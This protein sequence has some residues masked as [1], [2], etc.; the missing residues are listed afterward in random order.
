MTDLDA[1]TRS[2][3]PTLLGALEEDGP[4]DLNLDEEAHPAFDAEGEVDR[5]ALQRAMRSQ[6]AEVLRPLLD[7]PIAR[8]LL[9]AWCTWTSLREAGAATLAS[10]AP[11]TVDLS[12]R[13]VTLVK[14]PQVEV[15]VDGVVLATL[16]FEVSVD[17]EA[18]VLG[19]VVRRGRLAELEGG[20]CK[21]T[22][23]LGLA[24]E[25]LATGHVTVTPRL[26]LPLGDGIPLADVPGQRGVVEGVAGDTPG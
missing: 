22:V 3:A 7:V 4:L 25:T 13:S 26:H 20:A 21:A 1:P 23:R 10:D 2:D 17:V 16:Q 15:V 6:L 14:K 11:Q 18:D 8:P 5:P 24:G 19:A 12:G 9:D